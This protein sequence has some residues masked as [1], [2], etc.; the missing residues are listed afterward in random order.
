MGHI[1]ESL[2]QDIPPVLLDTSLRMLQG[3]PLFS[4]DAIKKVLLLF[5]RDEILCVEHIFDF[6]YGVSGEVELLTL[7]QWGFHRGCCFRRG[8]VIEVSVRGGRF[9]GSHRFQNWFKHST[10]YFTINPNVYS[11]NEPVTSSSTSY[12]FDHA[13]M[14]SSH[15]FH[16]SRVFTGS[17]YDRYFIPS[18]RAISFVESGVPDYSL[19]SIANPNQCIHGTLLRSY[20][21]AS[22]PNV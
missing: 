17:K 8:Y 6:S 14:W 13:I 19:G 20:I 9:L 3:S 16:T 18:S 10:S 2:W 5:E 21:L 7:E 1:T 11:V 15:R 22:L 4:I 12:F